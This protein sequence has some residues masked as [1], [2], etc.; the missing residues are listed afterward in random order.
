MCARLVLDD[1]EEGLRGDAKRFSANLP[2]ELA[3]RLPAN[4]GDLYCQRFESQYGSSQLDRHQCEVRPV[5]ERLVVSHES[6]PIELT[7]LAVS[8]A[9]MML[10]ANRPELAVQRVMRPRETTATSSCTRRSLSSS[11]IRKTSTLS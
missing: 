9:R 8:L 10:A 4:L 11:L 3:A 2:A 6:V 1:V 5:L 7:I